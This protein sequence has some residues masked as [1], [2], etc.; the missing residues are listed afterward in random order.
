MRLFGIC[1][2]ATKEQ[3]NYIFSEA[4]SIGPNGTKHMVLMLLSVLVQCSE[5]KRV[6]SQNHN[7]GG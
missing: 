2:D 3:V 6:L 5:L 7:F 1:N 4:E